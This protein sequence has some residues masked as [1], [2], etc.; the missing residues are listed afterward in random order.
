LL[1]EL[2]C[3]VGAVEPSNNGEFPERHAR[4]DLENLTGIELDESLVEEGGDGTGGT[5]RRGAVVSSCQLAG[6]G[7]D[8]VPMFRAT[9][10]AGGR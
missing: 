7:E 1:A 9:G 3:R 5:L 2:R 4:V 8:R 10:E 6:R